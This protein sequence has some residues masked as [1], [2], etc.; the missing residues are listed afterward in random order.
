MAQTGPIRFSASTPR[1]ES[2]NADQRVVTIVE[3]PS[4]GQ[5]GVS[6]L[7]VRNGQVV[8]LFR[9]SRRR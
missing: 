7:L 3:E 1:P 4:C 8:H 5:L 2:Q 9:S 6:G